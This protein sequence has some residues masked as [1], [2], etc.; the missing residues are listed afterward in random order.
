[1]EILA[2]RFSGLGDIVMLLPTLQAIKERYSASITL[3]CDATNAKIKEISCGVIDEVIAVKREAFRQRDLFAILRTISRLL[4]L[5]K[6]YDRAYDFQS[7]GESA[8]IACIAGRERIG[9][10]KR[11]WM[12]LCYTT[13]RPFDT[14]C[15]R[16][17][18]FAKIAGVARVHDPKLCVV[19][20]SRY[21]KRLD[22]SKKTIGLNIGST[23][24]SR[25]WSEKKFKEL[26]ERFLDDCNVLVF[27]GPK[28]KRFL[29]VFDERFIKVADVD[30]VELAATIKLCDLFVSNDTGPVH[31]AAALGV[32]TLTLFSTGEDWQVGC[33]SERKSF[34]K[35]IPID[36]IGVDEVEQKVR[37]LLCV[38]G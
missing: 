19:Q 29:P 37:E 22:P 28:E 12:E 21:G 32:A 30:L 38:H 20:K 2:I 26:G 4:G 15:H 3:L 9:A 25:R 18:F 5:W 11:R 10:V 7:F 35:R 34:I 36:A 31:M 17:D 6:K 27:F 8:I 33:L 14:S 24:E 23:K 1:M 13:P 16:S